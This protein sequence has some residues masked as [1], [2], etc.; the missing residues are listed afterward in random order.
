MLKNLP[1][2][3]FVAFVAMYFYYFQKAD[4]VHTRGKYTIGYTH[5]S[6]WTLKSGRQVDYHFSVDESLYKGGDDELPGMERVN[7]RYLIKYDSINPKWNA[8]YFAVPVPANLEQA[9]PHGWSVPPFP[10][11]SEVLKR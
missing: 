8:I 9:P 11:P 2:F 1:I 10:V 3:L 5:G 4:D 7:G 6:H